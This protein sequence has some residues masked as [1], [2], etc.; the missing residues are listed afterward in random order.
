VRITIDQNL[1]EGHSQ[2]YFVAPEL[3]NVDKQGYGVVLVEDVDDSMRELATR[4]ANSCPERA[5]RVENRQS[6][7]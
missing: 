2:C 5:I 7:E 4:A 1:C 6:T 3:F